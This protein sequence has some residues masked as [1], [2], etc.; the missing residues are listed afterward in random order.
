MTEKTTSRYKDALSDSESFKKLSIQISLN[1]LSFFV[2]DTISQKVV[3]DDCINFKTETTPYLLKKE[4]KNL[5]EKHE[6]TTFSFSTV[7]VIH[8]ND[9]FSLVPISLFEPDE[10]PNYLKFNTKLLANDQISFDE[11]KNHEIVSVYVPFTNIN[12]FIF[13]LYG[14]FDYTHSSTTLLQSLFN[15]KIGSKTVC[16]AHVNK[17]NFELVVFK[18]K[19]LLLFNQFRYKTKE[20]FLYYILFTYEQL[21][22][23]VEHVKLKLFGT[24]EEDDPLFNICYQYI[25]KVSVFE[26]THKLID[27]ETIRKHSIDLTILSSF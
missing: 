22:L 11:L 23:D 27:I 8:K 14:E 13:D 1:G 7:T 25:K 15:Q 16:Y 19:K 3:I 21:D 9:M 26:P 6:L 18:Q 5:L 10:L 2:L 20:D 17:F 24:I 12:N 4:L